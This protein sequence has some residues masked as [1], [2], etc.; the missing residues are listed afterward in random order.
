MVQY[1][2]ICAVRLTSFHSRVNIQL[3]ESYK[4][5]REATPG[6]FILELEYVLLVAK[7]ESFTNKQT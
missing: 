1:V 5:I 7:F 3:R 2:Q 4:Q 6:L